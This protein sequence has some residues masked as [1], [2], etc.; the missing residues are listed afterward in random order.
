MRPWEVRVCLT[1]IAIALSVASFAQQSY[2][3]PAPWYSKSVSELRESSAWKKTKESVARR[4][5]FLAADSKGSRMQKFGEITNLR[6]A[7]LTEPE[8][9]YLL[10]E[11]LLKFSNEIRGTPISNR[12]ASAIQSGQFV[13]EKDYLRS[14]YSST[15]LH[16]GGNLTKRLGRKLIEEYPKDFNLQLAYITDSY[17]GQAVNEDRIYG[18]TV[19]ENCKS[20]LTSFQ[21]SYFGAK[22][23]LA[24]TARTKEKKWLEKATER[25][26]QAKGYA[27][28]AEAKQLVQ[29]MEE[30]LN[31]LRL[32]IDKLPLEL[33]RGSNYQ[34]LVVPCFHEFP[35]GAGFLDA[36]SNSNFGC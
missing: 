28:S 9:A 17:R 23:C 19:L 12:F 21:Y 30:S 27:K 36:G 34:I 10:S 1:L 20:Q 24:L 15:W 11:I 33:T 26:S 16:L 13:N 14:L 7:E 8:D 29:Q 22:I 3:I 32:E 6:Y 25:A 18:L 31:R 5:S 4:I 35:G 2:D